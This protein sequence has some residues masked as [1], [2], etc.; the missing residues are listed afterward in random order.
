MFKETKER[1]NLYYR[2]GRSDK[3]YQVQLDHV[4]GGFVVNF[5]FGR[6]GSSLQSG[7]KTPEPVPYETAS[8]IYGRL[9]AE[10]K[11][12]GYT[13]SETGTPYQNPA[14]VDRQSTVLPQLL[15]AIDEP[16]A[17]RMID[18]VAWV[19]QEKKDGI[20][21]L[22]EKSGEIVRAM[23]RKGQFIGLSQA[24]ER[25]VRSLNCNAL[26]DGEA[27]GDVYWVFDLLEFRGE[28]LRA[29]GVSS[30]LTAL[31]MLL[32]TS[33][34]ADDVRLIP[35]AWTPLLKRATFERLKQ[36][37]AEGVVF[38]HVDAKY[39]PGK[40]NSGGSHLKFKFTATATC[41]VLGMN[42]GK[43]SVAIAVYQDPGDGFVEVGNVA[44][45][46]NYS[47][48]ETGALV[49][50]QY[51]YAYPGG[52]L[53]QPVYLGERKDVDCADSAKSLKFKQGEDEEC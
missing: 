16:E 30:R 50:V 42:G 19:M 23:N 43:R 13:V 8:R 3:V 52:S 48:P 2:D 27:V 9:L 22:V 44:I 25:A 11:A 26:L 33:L 12:K 32:E 6:R 7:T 17:R 46:P 24:I 36:E 47:I 21:L 28:D 53:Y 29:L 39:V 49:E 37:R 38:K 4:D 14:Q 41:K 10:K 20:R 40:P 51:L 31:T 5:Q 15:N 18:D 45:P 35:S 1:T 34:K